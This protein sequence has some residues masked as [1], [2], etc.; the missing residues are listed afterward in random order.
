MNEDLQIDLGVKLEPKISKCIPFNPEEH[1][2]HFINSFKI[3]PKILKLNLKSWNMGFC[4]GMSFTAREHF[5]KGTQ[6]PQDKTTPKS[7]TPL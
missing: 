5:L 4:G 6:I 3:S 1:G 2:F 7:G